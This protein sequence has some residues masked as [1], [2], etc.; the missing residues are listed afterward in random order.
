ML[1]QIFGMVFFIFPLIG[2][3]LMDIAKEKVGSYKA[4]RLKVFLNVFKDTFK[5]M[6]TFGLSALV[7]IIGCILPYWINSKKNPITQ[8]SNSTWF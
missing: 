8:N 5:R 4:V 1:H 7:L 3:V 6:I 2:T